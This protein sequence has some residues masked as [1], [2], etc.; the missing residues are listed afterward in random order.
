MP[1]KPTNSRKQPRGPDR[2]PPAGA[3]KKI[4][5]VIADEH[6]LYRRGLR[7][8]LRETERFDLAGELDHGDLALKAILEQK[9]DVAVL[10]IALPGLASLEIAARLKTNGSETHLVL[11]ASQND[12]K[13]FNQ[14]MNLGVR[15]YVLKK[16]SEREILECILAAAGGDAYVSPALTDFL[17]RR[18][19]HT[20]SLRRQQPGLAHL[21]MRERRVLRRIAQGKTSRQIGSE[22]G[23]SPRTVD[24]HRAHIC[25]K[26][27][28][29]GRNRLL[30][31]A[32]EHRD[33]LSHFE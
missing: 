14:A 30:Q 32:L 26:L 16:N 19:N 5:A 18:R 21:T 2:R 1:P 20:D 8:L 13:L 10:D 24:S 25:D 23:I 22:C 9:P 15:G 4:R 27:G 29:S 31:F 17:L 7:E 33:A 12:E 11:L 28:L 3:K 6:S